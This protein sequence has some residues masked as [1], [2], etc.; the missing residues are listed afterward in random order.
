MSKSARGVLIAIGVVLLLLVVAGAAALYIIGRTM[1]ARYGY[2][3]PGMMRGFGFFP[4]GG[5]LITLV[6]EVLIVAGIVWLI[7]SLARGPESAYRNLNQPNQLNQPLANETPLDILK[8]RYAS[9]EITK[10]QFDQMRQDIG[11]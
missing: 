4:F 5:G 6:I 8:R 2:I 1:M 11:V 3:G 10:E 9:G 7:A